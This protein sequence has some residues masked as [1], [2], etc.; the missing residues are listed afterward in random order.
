MEHFNKLFKRNIC[1][2]FFDPPGGNN[3][4]KYIFPPRGRVNAFRNPHPLKMCTL[5]F[6]EMNEKKS[7]KG[8]LEF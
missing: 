4:S 6:F 1:P 8:N 7:L 5:N 3:N 2:L